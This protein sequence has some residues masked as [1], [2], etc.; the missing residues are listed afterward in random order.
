M[1]KSSQKRRSTA[2]TVWCF[3]DRYQTVCRNV[4]YISATAPS[5]L[6][7]IERRRAQAVVMSRAK[8]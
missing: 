7:A 4:R 1:V 6:A 5:I 2:C 8:L 3:Y